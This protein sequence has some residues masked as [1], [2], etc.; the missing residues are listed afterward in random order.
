MPVELLGKP[1]GEVI[2]KAE[3]NAAIEKVVEAHGLKRR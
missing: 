3:V 1:G 2:Q